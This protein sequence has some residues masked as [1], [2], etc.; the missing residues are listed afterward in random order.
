MRGIPVLV[1]VKSIG[2]SP[3]Y[4]AEDSEANRNFPTRVRKQPLEATTGP[5][6]LTPDALHRRKVVKVT[7]THGHNVVIA[8]KLEIMFLGGPKGD[9]VGAANGRNIPRGAK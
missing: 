9:V 5:A 4:S 7:Q 6:Q 3:I 2:H 8:A 1:G